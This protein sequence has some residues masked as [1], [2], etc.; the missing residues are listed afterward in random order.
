M[1]WP[2]L[3]ILIVIVL[4]RMFFAGTVVSVVFPAMLKHH[5]YRG[6]LWRNGGPNTI[7]LG[8]ASFAGFC[9]LAAGIALSLGIFEGN[10]AAV[11]AFP[12]IRPDPDVI[13]AGYFLLAL[14]PGIWEELAFRGLIQSRLR[15]AFSPT[16]SILL[17]STF[18]GLYHLSNLVTQP[19]SMALPGAIMALFFG[20]GWGY[21]TCKS[22]SIFPAM[23]SHYLVDSMGQ[24]FLT[25]NSAVPE[26]A[27]AFFLLLTLLYPAFNFLITRLMFE[28][29]VRDEKSNILP[30]YR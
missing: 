20:M 14:V 1:G 21:M 10:I 6:S 17:S 3:S 29:R 5:N 18:F 23:I 13:G 25:V 8:F 7:F 9:L 22:R 16:T 30:Q 26:L 15:T 24:I 27:A 19:L 12:D 4:V 11:F 28:K 2:L